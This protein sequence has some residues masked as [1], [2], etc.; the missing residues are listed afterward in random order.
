MH[1][2]DFADYYT[3]AKRVLKKNG[4]IAIFGYTLLKIN[5]KAD[6]IILHFYQN[7]V[8]PYW[9]PERQ[10]LE[11]NYQ[12]I[13]FP[14]EEIPAP[15]FEFKQSWSFERLIGYL[16]TWSAV[17]SFER[18]RG[19]NPVELIRKELL[20]SFGEIAEVNFPILLRVGRN[21]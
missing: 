9:A 10:Y 15:Q 6:K 20:E 4:L 3:E 21:I 1:W 5:P 7:I 17:K 12:S 11:Q 16:N 2:F 19:E 18:E 14:F 13:P 8:G